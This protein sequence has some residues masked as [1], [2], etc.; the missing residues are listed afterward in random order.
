MEQQRE[1]LT[2]R[3]AREVILR[4]INAQCRSPIYFEPVQCSLVQS[5]VP[6]TGPLSCKSGKLKISLLSVQGTYSRHYCAKEDYKY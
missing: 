6:L 3:E 1:A 5:Q 2:E 4:G